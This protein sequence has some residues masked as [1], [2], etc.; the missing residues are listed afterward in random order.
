MSKHGGRLVVEPFTLPGTGRG[1]NSLDPAGV[2]TGPDA[3][4]SQE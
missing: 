4:D 1:C 3:Y 2:L